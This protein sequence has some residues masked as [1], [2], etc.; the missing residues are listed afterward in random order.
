M[1]NHQWLCLSLLTIFLSLAGTVYLVA[2]IV[3]NNSADQSAN[4]ILML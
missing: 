4:L 3:Q 2:I 1:T